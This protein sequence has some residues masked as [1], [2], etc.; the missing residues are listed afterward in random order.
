M[1]ADGFCIAVLTR[2]ALV[3]VSSTSK[4]HIVFLIGRASSGGYTPAASVMIVSLGGRRQ[5]LSCG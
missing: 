4:R 5:L 3:S 1:D 2:R